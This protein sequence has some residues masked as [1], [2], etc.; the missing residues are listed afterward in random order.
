MGTDHWQARASV[1]QRLA[2]GEVAEVCMEIYPSSTLFRAGE[3]LELLIAGHEIRPSPPFRKDV[4]C[5][6]GLHVVHTGPKRP[7]HLQVPVIPASARTS[8]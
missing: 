3:S 8:G 2:S 6:R 4:S 7:S 5:N 1:S